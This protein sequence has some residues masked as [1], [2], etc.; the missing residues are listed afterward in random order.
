[1][2]T[3]AV[4]GLSFSL[5]PGEMLGLFGRTGSGKSTIVNILP[6]LIDPPAGT[7]FIDGTAVGDY[8]LDTL[9]AAFGIVPQTTFLF[10]ATIEANIRFAR[11]DATDDAVTEVGRLAAIDGDVAEF[12][13]GWKTVVGER[14]VTLSG[15]QRQRIAIAR[16]LLADPEILILD[17]ALSAVDTRTEERILDAV[18]NYRTGRATVIVSNRV[19]T[20]QHADQ[21]LILED[22]RV[23]QRGTHQTLVQQ[24]GL[25]REI[26][27]LQQQERAKE[28]T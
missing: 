19:S 1:M 27:E 9:R 15:G 2:T 28:H 14:G 7:V 11:P 16:A 12:P 6:R 5:K 21:I 4:E 22:G 17:D 8:D 18:L 13:D 20:L 23:A 10:S 26:F 25:Y 3:P 24:P